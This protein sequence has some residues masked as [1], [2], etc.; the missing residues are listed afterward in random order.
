MPSLEIVQVLGAFGGLLWFAGFYMI[1]F[2]KDRGWLVS[3]LGETC[4]AVAGFQV[5]AYFLTFWCSIW[6]IQ[7]LIA[8]RGAA[9][10]E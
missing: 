9:M 7:D 2:E 3:V 8:W 10:E 6:I 4:M 1:A 5:G